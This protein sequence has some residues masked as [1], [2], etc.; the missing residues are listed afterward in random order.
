MGES[1]RGGV[2]LF[3]VAW[4]S[5]AMA[6]CSALVCAAGEFAHPRLVAYRSFQREF[7]E[8]AKFA[9]LGVPLRAIGICNTTSGRGVPYSDYPPVWTG[10][11]QYDWACCDRQFDETLAASPDATFMVLVDL[12]SPLWLARRQQFDSFTTIVQAAAMPEWRT[13]VREYLHALVE[14]V[15]AKYGPRI[16]AYVPMAGRTTEWYDVDVGLSS[17]AKNTAWR[18]WCAK[19]GLRYRDYTPPETELGR[20]AFEDILFDPAS[21]REKIDYC[22][23]HNGLVADALLEMAHEIRTLVGKKKEI[24]VF[25]G[26]YCI[27][28]KNL[29]SQGHMDYERVMASPDVDFGIS[30]AT[31]RERACGFGT[32]SQ[33]VAGTL[34]RHGKRLV[35]EIDFWPHDLK[36]PWRSAARNYFHS[37]AD[38]V[39]GNMRDA[40]FAFVNG[41]SW[42]YFDQYG[43]YYRTPGLHEKIAQLAEIERRQGPDDPAPVADVLFV[44]DPQSAL[45]IKDPPGTTREGFVPM[46]GATEI[47]RNR[48]NVTGCAYEVCS[49]GDLAAMDLARYRLIVLPATFEITSVRERLL[50]EKVC[51]AGKTVLWT[52]APGI[53]DGRGLDVARVRTWAGVPFRTADVTTTAMPGGWT[54][55]YAYDYRLLDAAKVRALAQAAGVF[56][57]ADEQMPVAANARYLAVHVKG[58]G[59]KVLRLRSKCAKVVDAFSG[60]TLAEN[61]DRF[62]VDLASPDT[63][64]FEL[65]P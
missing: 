46:V 17:R 11:G 9:Q 41:C 21:E 50:R 6:A 45:L 7:A 58:G 34:R 8:T 59:R 19:R 43:D 64:L 31:Y 56:F 44:T 2:A 42:W 1:T 62:E 23:F 39:A 24:G 40:V 10:P 14:H 53:S 35:H 32:G 48:I 54:S 25:F 49:F 20:A 16:V 12:N 4:V 26:Y 30:P 63:R 18:A 22:R 36:L 57:Y 13:A 51:V 33:S 55:V 52:Y 5:T 37:A 38:D 61:T 47:L 28:G 29:A 65:V 27:D 60:Q 15:E 3:A